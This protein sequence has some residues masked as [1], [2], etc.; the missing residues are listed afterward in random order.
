MHQKKI[1]LSLPS[2]NYLSLSCGNV[3]QSVVVPL[4][5]NTLIDYFAYMRYYKTGEIVEM[6][7][8]PE[9]MYKQHSD[10]CGLDPVELKRV[11]DFYKTT[12]YMSGFYT[13]YLPLPHG[14]KNHEMHRKNIVLSDAFGINNRYY[15]F[16]DFGDYIELVGFASSR[17]QFAIA[18][19]INNKE[20]LEKFVFYFK[21]K[22]NNLIEQ[23]KLL[24][25]K[26]KF[27]STYSYQSDNYEYFCSDKLLSAIKLSKIPLKDTALTSQEL[28]ILIHY[29][30]GHSAKFIG[31]ILKI[32]SCT[33]EVHIAKAKLKLNTHSK[34]KLTNLLLE[35]GIDKSIL[36]L[37]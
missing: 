22:M 4:F 34:P 21:V 30:N 24:S 19:Y 8:N 13:N 7:T 10:G 5:T 28:K 15:L 36:A 6:C 17:T 27:L 18:E 12:Q 2:Q 14:L 25:K 23:I 37:L 33:V 3:L 16:K 11:M 32:S 1:N 20:L 9:F 35:S 26:D 31:E 29:I